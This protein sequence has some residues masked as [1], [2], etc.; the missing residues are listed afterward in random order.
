MNLN[1][2]KIRKWVKYFGMLLKESTRKRVAKQFKKQMGTDLNLKN[3][4]TFNE[5]LQWLKLYW[6]DPLLVSLADKVD[7]RDYVSRKVGDKYLVPLIAVC[8]SEKEVVA[9]AKGRKSAIKMAHASGWNVIVSDE[10]AV[11]WSDVAKKCREWFASN[12][13]FSSR[14]FQYRAIPHRAVVEELLVDQSGKIPKDFKF[15][16]F[17]NGSEVDLFVQVDSDRFDDHTRNFFTERWEPLDFGLKFK[18]GEFDIEKPTNF[19]EMKEVALTLSE[20]LPYVRVDLYDT[21]DKVYFGEM[22][23]MPEAG[24][25]TFTPNRYDYLWG[26]LLDLSA[27]NHLKKTPPHRENN[28]KLDN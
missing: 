9:A 24:Y 20:G 22:T 14:E 25:G 28:E 16:V 2:L 12:Y 5:K 6:R 13:Y 3:P 27:Y 7:A 1:Y 17:R 21:G 23:F 19:E 11:D 18:R 8:N 26:E 10:T 15:H 4:A